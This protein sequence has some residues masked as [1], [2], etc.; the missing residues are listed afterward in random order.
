MAANATNPHT[1]NVGNLS[2]SPVSKY[3]QSTG[4]KNPPEIKKS[5]IN[6]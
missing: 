4:K 1:I 3:S 5:T 6:R 2:T